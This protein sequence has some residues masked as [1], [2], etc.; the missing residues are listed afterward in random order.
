MPHYCFECV[1]RFVLW[2]V[3]MSF[4]GVGGLIGPTAGG[5][6]EIGRDVAIFRL[7]YCLRVADVCL[8]NECGNL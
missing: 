3:L 8:K 1:A 4:F 7:R 5:L 6:A 2:R